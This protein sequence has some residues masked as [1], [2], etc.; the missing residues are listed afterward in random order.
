MITNDVCKKLIEIGFL[1]Q[2][3]L[4]HLPRYSNFVEGIM[5][6]G[7][8]FDEI[9]EVLKR[10][11][12]IKS[13]T[14]GYE[15]IPQ[16]IISLLP[17]QLVQKHSIVP[18]SLNHDT[19][20]IAV[21]NPFDYVAIED[22]TLVTSYNV[23]SLFASPQEIRRLLHKHYGIEHLNDI[24]HQ[25]SKNSNQ[26]EKNNPLSPVN[27]REQEMSNDIQNAP[28]VRLLDTIVE[29][30]IRINASDIHIEPFEKIV[31]TRYRVDG[32]LTEYQNF[33][34]GL[35][36]NLIT[37]L[38][39]ISNLD[40]SERRLPQDGHILKGTYS[41]K[42]DFRV[43]I[44]PNIFGEKAVIRLIY[45]KHSKV[46]KNSLG[47]FPEDIDDLTTLFNN[48]H[49][50]ILVT[51]PTGSG[52]TTT[53]AAFLNELNTP[54]VN[55]VTIEDPVENIIFGINQINVTPKS[56]LDFANALRHILRQ[57]PD[58]IMV[59]EIRDSET[60][61]TAIRA[62]LTGHLVLST[63]HTNDASSSI[64]RLLD[65]GVPEYLLSAGL[66]GVISQRLMRRLC[67]NCKTETVIAKSDAL[68]L[69]ISDKTKICESVGCSHCNNT[70]YR[71]RFAV[72]EY[73]IF[74]D[75]IRNLINSKIPIEKIRK[76]LID[77]GMKTIW[78][79]ALQNVLMGNSSVS[80]MYKTAFQS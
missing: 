75:E 30:A 58:I 70:G 2:E 72:Y 74:N 3:F 80:E 52:K 37:R 59:G 26:L 54:D 21:S 39:I 27:A 17:T 10:E 36:P 24:I 19:L 29:T 78:H 12:D 60:A 61:D 47:F 57:D 9:S 38:K 62:A 65:M 28:A 1:P 49:G 53:L 4:R 50:A 63:L 66:K 23:V 67:D 76:H 79:N 5:S 14:L 11:F 18:I 71:G 68:I 8:P 56:G 73:I 35:L 44:L 41:D 6:W 77:S 33:D 48:N 22:V 13:I 43:S 64:V 25:F 31:R 32:K 42:I 55:I 69:N 40:T 34:I 45:S 15:E 7:F 16:D 20:T 46:D 51:G